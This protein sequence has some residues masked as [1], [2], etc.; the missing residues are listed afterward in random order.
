MHCLF[1]AFFFLHLS[2]DEGHL[3]LRTSTI[4]SF[5]VQQSQVHSTLPI[6]HICMKAKPL[7]NIPF[8]LASLG[9]SC[10]N[11]L[12]LGCSITRRVLCA[13]TRGKRKMERYLRNFRNYTP[14]KHCI[15]KNHKVFKLI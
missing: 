1:L 4:L 2:Q 9:Q 13:E 3:Q 15:N 14:N 12:F 6:L 10:L 8:P 5:G 7:Q 11:F